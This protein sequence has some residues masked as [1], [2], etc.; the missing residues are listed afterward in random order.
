MHPDSNFCVTLEN[1][2]PVAAYAW[3][4]CACPNAGQT[5]D[6]APSSSKPFPHLPL[7]CGAPLCHSRI[8]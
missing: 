8:N 5:G 4:A 3:G 1:G 2:T 7:M 6:N